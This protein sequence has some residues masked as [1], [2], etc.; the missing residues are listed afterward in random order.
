MR[1]CIFWARKV[2]ERLLG[3]VA[4]ETFLRE[5][6]LRMPFS[7]PHAADQFRELG[8]W[9]T[10][11][12]L[13]ERPDADVLVVGQG[14]RW[15]ENRTPSYEEA[16]AL[17]RDGYTL[18]VRH[19]E[20]EDPK[21]AE[22]AAG[23]ARDF[24]APVDI[25]LYCT[26]Q[27]G[28]HGFGWHYDAEDVFILQT[29]GRKEYSLRK[30]TV[31]PWPLVETLPDD[32]KFERELMPVLRCTLAA[33]DWLYI[34]NGFWHV[35]KAEEDSLSLAVG[36]EMPAALH[37]YD[38]LRR[39]LCESLLWR[40]RLPVTGAANTDSPQ[41]LLERYRTLFAD[42]GHD[43]HAAFR[44]DALLFSYLASLGVDVEPLRSANS[45]VASGTC[46]S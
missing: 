18:L 16:Q 44:E 8:S 39:R 40:Q 24:L 31:N 21:L 41:E 1:P 17:F 10:V 20:K 13:L 38:F 42:L 26:P 45:Q 9:S 25:H 12:R 30:N 15:E 28:G 27:S 11:E 19:A 14:R 33:G 36:L 3:G 35:A 2:I 4:N 5:Y 7:L 32:M 22:L 46:E 29:A 43:L 23:F 34:P 6:F 37:V